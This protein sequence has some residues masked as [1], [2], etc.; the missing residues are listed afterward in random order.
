MTSTNQMTSEQLV[1]ASIHRYK[2]DHSD[3]EV[4]LHKV[5]ADLGPELDPVMETHS[6]VVKSI[7]AG[8]ER[9]KRI[10]VQIEKEFATCRQMRL[11]GEE[12]PEHKVPKGKLHESVSEMDAW[13]R[14]RAEIERQ[15]ADELQ[16][17]ADEQRLRADRFAGWS[18]AVHRV[19]EKVVEAGHNPDELTYAE[20]IKQQA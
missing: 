9:L 2:I 6:S 18:Q 15:N 11:Y 7:K 19:Y 3:P 13:M 10:T 16:E 8:I 5:I 20:A 12:I 1:K 17:L 14:S 4:L